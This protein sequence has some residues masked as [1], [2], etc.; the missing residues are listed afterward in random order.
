MTFERILFCFP[1]PSLDAISL[2]IKL[3]SFSDRSLDLLASF[4]G[5]MFLWLAALLSFLSLLLRSA[6]V[7]LAADGSSSVLGSVNEGGKIN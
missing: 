7:T 5:A 1:F 2:V 3:L 4:L 6:S